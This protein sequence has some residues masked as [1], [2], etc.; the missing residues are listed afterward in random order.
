[1]RKVTFLGMRHLSAVTVLLSY[2]VITCMVYNYDTR[3]VIFGIW[4]YVIKET[5]NGIV[6]RVIVYNRVQTPYR[7]I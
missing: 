1:M 3:I 5:K 2:M 6:L 4:V 7:H